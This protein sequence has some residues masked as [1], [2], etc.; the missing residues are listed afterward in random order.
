MDT[1]QLLLTFVQEMLKYAVKG[2]IVA[3][4]QISEDKLS[5]HM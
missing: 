4:N 1:N 3:D 2:P 5:N